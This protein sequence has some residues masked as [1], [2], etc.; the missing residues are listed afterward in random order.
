MKIK[1]V[2]TAIILFSELILASGKFKLE[3]FSIRLEQIT[4][5]ANH[6]WVN[7][8]YTTVNPA[9]LSVTG[10]NDFYS[11]PFG[12]KG[13]NL[14]VSFKADSINIE[15]GPD[16]GKG[17]VGLLYSKGVWYPDK[18]VRTGTYH[19]L[20]GNVLY[21]F[22]IKSELIP[23]Y[24]MAGFMEKIEITNRTN[25]VIKMSM[26]SVITPGG[27]L[28]EPL[29]KWGF[30]I[31]RW[32][33]GEAEKISDNKWQTDKARISFYEENNEADVAPGGTVKYYAGIVETAVG[34]TAPA[35]MDFAKQAELTK[36]T[37]EKR[38]QTYT[39]NIPALQSNIPGLKE[40][41]YR[42]V[43]SGLVCIWE[44]NKYS[45]NPHISTAGM[46]GG[47]TCAYLWDVGGY[48]PQMIMLMMDKNANKLAK[49]MVSIDLQKY[50]A[51]SLDGKGLGVKYSYSPVAF[52]SIVSAYFK[53]VGPDKELYNA[54][55]RLILSDEERENKETHLIDYGGQENLLEMRGEGYEHY[56][57]SPNA[58]R[59]WCLN[60]LAEMGAL[61]GEDKLLIEQMKNKAEI[62]K[63]SIREQ[64]WDNNKKWFAC[65]YPNGFK[66]YVY[67]IQNYDALPSGVCTGE[68]EK[69]LVSHL[70]K[71]AFLCD[72][73]VTSVSQEDTLHYEV[74]DT[75][76]SGGGSYIG[77]GLQL[78]LD[79][80]EQNEKE[81]AWEILNRHLWMGKSLIYYP[82][83]IYANKPFSPTHKRANSVAGL[84]GAETILFG[85][86]GLQA[87]YDGSLYVNPN[88]VDKGSVSINGYNFGGNM[89]DIELSS[90]KLKIIANG[91]TIYDGIPEKTKIF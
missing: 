29:A 8:G 7:S 55:K 48:A 15:D 41:Y 10:V 12:I 83:E 62:I 35:T 4:S 89:V 56:V 51:F 67:S 81:I 49:Q 69:A 30:S 5:A 74:I 52:T 42:S 45:L 54:A 38:L 60:R 75:D 47:G 16:Y 80:Y 91:K 28:N 25:H 46:D 66:D 17:D 2:F 72:Y 24:G 26:K 43:I 78:S 34:E 31:A 27:L 22:T 11:P 63:K 76:W 39:R 84:T 82:Q 33:A 3:D 13:F 59:I 88:P 85:M 32:K 6:I 18:I 65:L 9:C 14:K 77:D 37:W 21:S 73:G 70:R 71:G 23:L 57:V 64:L 50:Y 53:Y 68:M 87:N 1:I 79:L 86:I 36:N 44:N 58:E 90:S 61:A 20:K 19:H 40:F